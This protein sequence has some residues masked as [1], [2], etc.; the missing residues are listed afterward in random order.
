MK[1]TVMLI[2]LAVVFAASFVPTTTANA[3][4]YF[5]DATVI[6]E[7]VNM[8]MRPSTDS[9]VITQLNE[10]ARI[11]VFCEEEPGWYRIIY[12]NYR[13]YISADYVFLPSK[14]Y[15][16]AHVQEGGLNMREN[17]GVYSTVI[18]KLDEG[19]GVTIINFFGEWYE[20][21]VQ[22]GI[23][24]DSVIKT[25]YVHSDYLKIS[26]ADRV[27]NILKQGMQGAA[28]R[29]LQTELRKRK[30]MIARAT[31]YYGDVT[32]GAVKAFQKEAGLAQ[33]G[34]VGEQTYELIF[35]EN[36]ISTTVAKMFGITGEVKKSTWDE[37]AKVFTKGKI[38]TVTDVKTGKSF[39]VR[40]FGGWW[41][42]DV[43]PLTAADTAIMKSIY[44]GTW[45]WDRRA[46]WVTVGGQTFAASQNGMP[47]L[48]SPTP[49]NNFPG[50]FC[51]H[52]N[53]SKVH[54]TGREGPR[55]QYMVDYA[56]NRAH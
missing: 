5:E 21:E 37:I 55:H 30:F 44:N 25:G 12:G 28:V 14:D 13:G 56:Y 2:L 10:G 24:E 51:I 29:D 33:D 17:P 52:F 4:P 48:A 32:V 40:R 54:E 43:E 41:H 3:M 18:M 38:A 20:I 22:V 7:E 35:G 39:R 8:R 34:I 26:T 36:D 1:K 53:D 23:G 45:S 42:A 11:G 9:P 16:I 15:M 27:T 50:H 31:G 6:G 46:I 47:H 49:D 19:T